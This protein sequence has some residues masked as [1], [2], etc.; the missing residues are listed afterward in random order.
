MKSL[1]F[2]RKTFVYRDIPS[3]GVMCLLSI[4]RYHKGCRFRPFIACLPVNRRKNLS[5]RFG[6]R[7]GNGGITYANRSVYLVE[8]EKI[9]PSGHL[10]YKE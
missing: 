3:S 9:P 8:L 6:E 4:I 1:R 7:G 10:T 2:I 5:I